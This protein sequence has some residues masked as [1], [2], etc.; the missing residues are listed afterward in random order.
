MSET[1]KLSAVEDEY[2]TLIEF[3]EWLNDQGIFLARHQQQFYSDGTPKKY[4]FLEIVGD[5]PEQTIYKFFNIDQGKLEQERRQ[6]LA[7]IRAANKASTKV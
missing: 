3:L 1:D 6:A 5:R 7:D 4:I 2:G